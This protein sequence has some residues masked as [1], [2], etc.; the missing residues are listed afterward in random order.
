MGTVAS[1]HIVSY[2]DTAEDDTRDLIDASCE[3]LHLADEKFSTFK[4]ES[5]LTQFRDGRLK[6]DKVSDELLEVLQLC[7]QVKRITLGW[8]DP[9]A[10]AGGFDPTGLVKGWATRNSLQ[11]LRQPGI[12]G[13]MV[14]VGGD[15]CIFGQSVQGTQW[16]VGIQHPWLP[17]SLACS[18]EIDSAIATS[19]VYERGSHLFDPFA[20]EPVSRLASASVIGPDLALADAFATALCVQ[21]VDGLEWINSLVDYDAYLITNEGREYSTAGIRFVDPSENHI[22]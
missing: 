16:N 7:D 4:P 17:N 15:I 19:G 22:G 13:A 8:F 10:M 2:T 12:I 20:H 14:N 18:I 1:L 11:L 5:E 9:W 21:G 6:L 3:V